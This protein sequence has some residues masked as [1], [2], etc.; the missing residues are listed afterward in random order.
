MIT[1]PAKL[2]GLTMSS[3]DIRAGMALVLAA[4]CAKGRSVI[5]N[6]DMIYRGY[7][8]LVP[9]LRSIGVNVEEQELD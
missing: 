3:P 6:A 7:E 4:A 5:N 9:K 2:R 1:G 8:D